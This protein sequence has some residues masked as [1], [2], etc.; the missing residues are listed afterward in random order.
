MCAPFNL[1]FRVTTL[2]VFSVSCTTIPDTPT[3]A[4]FL[5][6]RTVSSKPP[7]VNDIIIRVFLTR[8]RQRCGLTGH[9]RAMK[10]RLD[11]LGMH[12]SS[13]RHRSL[14]RRCRCLGLG[15]STRLSSVRV[16]VHHRQSKQLGH[17]PKPQ[18]M[19][20]DKRIPPKKRVK[21][22]KSH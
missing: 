6:L 19:Q 17:I 5:L 2:N 4:A 3:S 12:P 11:E 8:Q 1:S 15:R 14:R 10:I 21:K 9:D 18:P 7:Q 20:R 13:R 22:S 16:R